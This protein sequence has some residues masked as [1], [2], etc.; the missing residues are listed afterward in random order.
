[1]RRDVYYAARILAGNVEFRVAF[2]LTVGLEIGGA[3]AVFGLINARL[4][5]GPAHARAHRL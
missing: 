5:S 3:T 4:F 2:V 1:M